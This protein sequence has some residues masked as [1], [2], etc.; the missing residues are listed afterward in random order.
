MLNRKYRL[1][2]GHFKSEKILSYPAFVLKIAKNGKDFSRF[3]FVVS[4]K[5]DKRATER[6]RIKRKLR[7]CIEDKIGEIAKGYDFLFIMKENI[8]EKNYCE[9]VLSKLKEEIY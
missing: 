4:K 5:I 2:K 3:T 9:E 7:R 1:P 6:N 8:K